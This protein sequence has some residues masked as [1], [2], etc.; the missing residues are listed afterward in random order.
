MLAMTVRGFLKYRSKPI[1]FIPVYVG[2]EKLLESKA[3]QAELSGEIKKRETFIDS[4]RSMLRIRGEFG[5]VSANFGQPVFLNQVLDQ[6]HPDWSSENYNDE[7]RPTWVRDVVGQLATSIMTHINQAATVNSINLISSVF[8]CHTAPNHGRNRASA[9]T[10]N[11]S[12]T[13]S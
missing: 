9:T 12:D 10:G 4:V 2:Y 11:I 13:D 6:S 5:K 8:T 1:A 3:Y 7:L